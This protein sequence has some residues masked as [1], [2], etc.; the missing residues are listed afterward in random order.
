MQ[1]FYQGA[2]HDFFRKHSKWVDGFTQPEF[3]KALMRLRQAYVD[4]AIDQELFTNKT[5]TCRE[6]FFA[7]KVGIFSY[8]AGDWGLKLDHDTKT[9]DPKAE[10]IAIPAIRETHYI[11]RIGSMIAITKTCKNPEAVF[12]YINEYM[13]DGGQGEMLF[14]HGVEGV[15][16]A[17]KDGKYVKLPTL[18][19]PSVLFKKSYID[20]PLSI[21]PM[22]DPF[23]LDLKTK[24][25]MKAFHSRVV[26][27]TLPP[28]SDTYIKEA[29]DIIT[30]KREIIAKIIMGTYTVDEGL[31]LYK[32]KVSK[33]NIKKILEEA[34]QNK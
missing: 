5:S 7:G 33:Y 17:K 24:E 1:D 32:E 3:K 30:L 10:V 13:H 2:E 9:N 18:N 26:Q 19:N 12:K 34:N 11:N 14:T 25:S 29:A 21:G 23:D 31:K 8:W 6:K 27:M 16:W 28:S 15:N 22:V 4:R 20:A